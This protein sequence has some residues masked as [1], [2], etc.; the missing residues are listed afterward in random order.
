MKHIY[1]GPMTIGTCETCGKTGYDQT[2]H[3]FNASSDPCD[4]MDG[5]CACGAW[6][7]PADFDAAG[8][9]ARGAG[10]Q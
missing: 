4:M 8:N 7:K 9:A 1:Y 3:F 5:P 10:P 2:E 6:H